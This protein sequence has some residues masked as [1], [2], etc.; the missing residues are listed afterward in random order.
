MPF[1]NWFKQ[2][3]TAIAEK[4]FS[5]AGIILGIAGFGTQ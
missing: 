2:K 3:Y 5:N 1:V 4:R